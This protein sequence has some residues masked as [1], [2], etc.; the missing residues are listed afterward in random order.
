MQPVASYDGDDD[1][2]FSPLPAGKL[3]LD[4]ENSQMLRSSND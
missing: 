4:S 1:T 3:K 2:G